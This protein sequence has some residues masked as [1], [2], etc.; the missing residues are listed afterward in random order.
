[1]PNKTIH[2]IRS[3]GKSQQY[4][5]RSVHVAENVLKHVLRKQLLFLGEVLTD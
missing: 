3:F 4:G 2:L 1:M 5:Y